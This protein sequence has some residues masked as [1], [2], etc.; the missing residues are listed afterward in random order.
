VKVIAHRGAWSAPSE[1]NTEAAFRRA[2]DAGFGI[3]TD[4]RDLAGELVVSHDMPAGGEM[5][6]RAFLALPGAWDLPLAI[7][8]KADGM[9]APLGAALRAAGVRDA[10][11][12]D[13]SVPDALPYLDAGLPVFARLSEYEPESALLERAAGAWLDAF[14]GEWY[15][16]GT[17][18]SLLERGKQ[19]CVVSPELHRRPHESLWQMLEPWAAH[20]GLAL[21]TDHPERARA[22][23]ASPQPSAR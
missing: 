12:F 7:N 16:P 20:P 14:H 21:C 13:M 23:F 2:F 3:E 11:V 9:A 19:V 6:L 1:R 15:G 8:V 4:V 17:I 22:F 10:F 18:S 5:P